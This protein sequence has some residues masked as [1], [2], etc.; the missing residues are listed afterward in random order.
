MGNTAKPLVM[1]IGTLPISGHH[2][3]PVINHPAQE[4]SLMKSIQLRDVAVGDI[5]IFY[6]HQLDAD[7]TEIAVFPSREREAFTAH[8]AK[9]MADESVILKTI[10][11]DGQVVGNIVSWE[12]NGEREIGYWIGK[13]YWGKGIATQALAE[14]LGYVKVRPVYAYVAKHNVGS[15]RVLEKCGFT[16]IGEANDDVEEFILKLG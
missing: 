11:F 12:Q 2:R 7:A 9:I 10:L 5:P 13:M 8:W 6:E 16:V 3:A 4:E 15:I 1:D 14:F